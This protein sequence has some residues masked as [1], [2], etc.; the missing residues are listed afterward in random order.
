MVKLAG[1]KGAVGYKLN[2]YISKIIDRLSEIET[3]GT[4]SEDQAIAI[5]VF[6][7]QHLEEMGLKK[8]YGVTRFYCDWTLHVSLD[9]K[10]VENILDNIF[11]VL[12]D[13]SLN[14]NDRV[15]ELLMMKALRAEIN[16]ILRDE[17]IVT[18]V[19]D[20]QSIWRWFVVR[21]LGL[22]LEKP[23]RRNKPSDSSHVGELTLIAP[24]AN[25]LGEEYVRKHKIRDGM[26]F[27]RIKRLPEDHVY[28]GPVAFTEFT[29]DFE[30]P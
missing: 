29:P 15:N 6:L 7:R 26:V 25:E 22:V 2:I 18:K 20:S 10:P 5:L 28:D 30:H 9:R 1:P 12:D 17:G 11:N 27:W 19:F 14:L 21:L 16:E 24:D 3:T 13:E 23:L 8:K 4:V